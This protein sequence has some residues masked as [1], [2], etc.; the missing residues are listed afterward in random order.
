MVAGLTASCPEASPAPDRPTEMFALVAVLAMERLP[1]MLPADVGVK[2]TLKVILW[3]AAKLT[4]RV[5]PA[6]VKPAPEAVI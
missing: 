6:T 2:S 3:P 4:G 1:L 5:T